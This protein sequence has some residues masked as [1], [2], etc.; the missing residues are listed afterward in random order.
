MGCCCAVIELSGEPKANRKAPSVIVDVVAGSSAA[1]KDC[2]PATDQGPSTATAAA[3][4]VSKP[5]AEGREELT[6]QAQRVQQQPSQGP[7]AGAGASPGNTQALTGLVA[8]QAAMAATVAHM[9]ALELPGA[10][11]DAARSKA[12]HGLAPAKG[13]DTPAPAMPQQPSSVMAG[14]AAA[15]T[16]T[17]LTTSALA[18]MLS[19]SARSQGCPLHPSSSS[20]SVGRTKSPPTLPDSLR[21][22]SVSLMNSAAGAGGLPGLAPLVPGVHFSGG[23][24]A[25]SLSVA[26]APSSTW[27]SMARWVS[28]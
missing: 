9:Q 20:H 18:G 4:V 28:E 11:G 15:D 10:D 13:A 22:R 8:D 5:I 7:A 1:G 2:A 12:A 3:A 21:A 14:F 27:H 19:G 24:G 6:G 25:S 17:T 16:T 26:G 23:A